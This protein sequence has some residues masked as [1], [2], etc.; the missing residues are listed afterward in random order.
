M[1]NRRYPNCRHAVSLI[2]RPSVTPAGHQESRWADKGQRDSRAEV[3]AT[4]RHWKLGVQPVHGDRG[5]V[6]QQ[7]TNFSQIW[8]ERLK[9]PNLVEVGEG[10]QTRE[11]KVKE[12]GHARTEAEKQVVGGGAPGAK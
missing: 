4:G 8:R 10:C 1:S 5:L 6:N 11:M 7:V 2:S 3:S 9:D 12:P